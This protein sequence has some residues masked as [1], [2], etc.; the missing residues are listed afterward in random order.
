MKKLKK[1]IL[2]LILCVILVLISGCTS[3]SEN[4]YEEVISEGNLLMLDA[5]EDNLPEEKVDERDSIGDE[6]ESSSVDLI[7][8]YVYSSEGNILEVIQYSDEG[9]ESIERYEYDENN[10]LIK[11]YR[12]GYLYAEFIYEGNLCIEEKYYDRT[13]DVVELYEYKYSQGILV[14]EFCE[15]HNYR[16]VENSDGGTSVIEYTEYFYREYNL[17]GKLVK[18]TCYEYESEPY[19]N[20]Y[21]YSTNKMVINSTTISG[22]VFFTETIIYD[23]EGRE[24]S[25]HWLFME[26]GS[27]CETRYS[28]DDNRFVETDYLDGE[29]TG[30]GVSEYNSEGNI[31]QYIYYSAEN[32][33]LESAEF[34]YDENNHVTKI[35]RMRHG[36]VTE[37]YGPEREYNEENQVICEIYYSDVEYY[38]DVVLYGYRLSY[39]K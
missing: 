13:G 5:E 38:S 23:E 16:E 36:Q 4:H 26:D 14:S 35:R 20:E 18:E 11:R 12:H 31:I 22:E 1:R 10:N 34:E 8:E 15:S 28:Y 37:L 24:I 19:T 27:T 39:R 29:I 32:E 9:K 21:I 33:M 2:L 30:Y 17:A 6:G 7:K 25:T 3:A